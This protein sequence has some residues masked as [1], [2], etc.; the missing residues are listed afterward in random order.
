MEKTKEQHNTYPPVVS[1]L[2]HVDHGKTTLLDSFRKSNIASGEAGGITQAIGASKI[3]VIHENVK[4]YITFIDTPG[5]EAF[6]NM[7]SHGVSASDIVLLI[8]AADDG[9]KPQTKES[10]E[11]ILASKLP[12]IVVLTK[13][14]APGANIEKVKQQLAKEGVLLEG[15]GGDVPVIAVSAKTG[16]KVADLLELIIIVYDYSDSKK[17]PSEAFIGVV[18]EAKLDKKRGILASLIIK[19]GKILVGNK[20]FTQSKEVGKVRAL[21]DSTGA[22]VKEAHP[23]EAVEILGLTEVLQAGSV[24]NTKEA[25]TVVVPVEADKHAPLD[26]MALL[27]NNKPDE[28]MPVIIKTQTSGEFEAISASLPD[29]VQVISE[30]RGEISVS[31]I[32]MSRDFN[33]I[34]V[35]FNVDIEKQ[36]K[37]LADSN[38]TFYRTYN[39]IYNLLDELKDAIALIKERNLR[40]ILGKAQILATFEGNEGQILGVRV[41]EGRLAVGDKIIV[42]K[43]E[44]ETPEVKI[45]SLKQGKKD[46]K[47]IGRGNECGIMIDPQVDF[48]IGDMIISCG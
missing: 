45:M 22:Q 27:K 12:Y 6:S 23:G 47:E 46:I 8:V 15:L 9:I 44:N 10:I 25:G 30:G 21:I 33:A 37:V 19:S 3:E 1:V 41:T 24:I 40:K 16:D 31:D 11:K 17:D 26:F 48:T 5:H 42:K 7:R 36:A 34:I 39:I 2:G 32:L 29:D 18:I 13:S 35:G 38:N 14:D 43:G 4:R 20:V 28:K